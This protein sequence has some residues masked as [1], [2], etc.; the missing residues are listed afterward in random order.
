MSAHC[1]SFFSS[2]SHTANPRAVSLSLRPAPWDPTKVLVHPAGYPIEAPPSYSVL[3]CKE[4]AP[5]VVV[6]RG[7]GAGPWDMVGDARL[8]SLS[9]KSHLTLH[10]QS[11]DMRLS[12]MSGHF[13]L[14]TSFTGRL[15]WKTNMLSG[16]ILELHDTSGT[17]IAT[18]QPSKTSGEKE[19]EIYVPHD[20][21]FL[22]LV[23]L[24]G[25]TAK[26]MTKAENEAAVEVLGSIL[27]A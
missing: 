3:I 19:L 1:S 12:Q 21:Q 8:P 9:S 15:K 18:I 22:E 11:I 20:G 5:N 4:K 26:A 16:R 25:M 27:G 14:Q 7:W 24:S 2:R 13:S 6:L 17:K 23:L 10:G